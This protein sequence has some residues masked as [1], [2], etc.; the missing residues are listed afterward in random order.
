MGNSQWSSA[1]IWQFREWNELPHQLEQRLEPSYDA[2]SKYLRLFGTSEWVAATGKLLVFLGGATGG[3][4]L[5]L[6]VLNDAILLHVQLWGRN[7]LWYAGMAGLVYSVGKALLPSKEATPSVTRNLFDDMDN[8]LKNVSVYTHYYPESWK[9]RGWDSSVYKSFK[10]YFDTRVKLFLWELISLVLAPYILYFR[11]STEASA[12]CEFCLLSKARVQGVGDV[13]GFSTFDFDVFKDEAWDGRT[14]GQSVRTRGSSNSQGVLT[15]TLE[16]SVMRTGN[17]EE[18]TKLHPKPRAREGKME[19]SFFTFRAAH[20]SFKCPAS[21]LKLMESVDEYRDASMAREQELHIEAAARQLELLARLERRTSLSS[22]LNRNA[23]STYSATRTH[24]N[25][26]GIVPA[27]DAG[28]GSSHLGSQRSSSPTYTFDGISKR[29]TSSQ[30]GTVTRR[31][32]EIAEKEELKVPLRSSSNLTSLNVSSNIEA[33]LG[34]ANSI[35]GMPSDPLLLMAAAAHSSPDRLSTMSQ[36]NLCAGPPAE[37]NADRQYYWLEK[38]HE[39]LRQEQ[40]EH[41]ESLSEAQH[42]PISLSGPIPFAV[43]PPLG[44]GSSDHDLNSDSSPS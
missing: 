7:L 40:D 44:Q 2:A 26:T 31:L 5:V 23:T 15:E 20:P 43:L 25:Q 21:G 22:Q 18:A 30:T 35:S 12:I 32:D 16:E 4:L 37:Q 13:C 42:P 3:V 17:L 8:A 10:V 39:H 36:S 28:A 1:A 27:A 9:G 24:I 19:K 41:E 29:I 34:Y 6:G 38:F 14:L 33:C 11:L